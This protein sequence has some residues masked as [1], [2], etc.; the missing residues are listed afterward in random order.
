[1]QRNANREKMIKGT[2][3]LPI[4]H[5]GSTADKGENKKIGKI[6]KKR[7][8]KDSRTVHLDQNEK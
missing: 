8:K 4:K 5:S 1:M 7:P 2:H 6:I 3:K